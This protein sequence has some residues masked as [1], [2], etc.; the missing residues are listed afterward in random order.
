MIIGIEHVSIASDD[1]AA[2][3]RLFGVFGLRET[4]AEDLEV[5]GVRSRQLDAGNASIEVLEPLRGDAPVSRFLAS[6]GPGLHH[7]CFEVDDLEATIAQMQAAGLRLVD[8]QPRE[9]SQGRRV[10]LHP[11]SGHGV[12][13]GFVQRHARG[14]A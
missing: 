3:L 5:E 12:L 2:V 1:V 13:M 6:R 10:F 4:Y 11:R 7:V 9:D 8:P 14:G